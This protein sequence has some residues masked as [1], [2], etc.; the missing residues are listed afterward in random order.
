MTDQS[1]GPQVFSTSS[2]SRSIS[3]LRTEAAALFNR[4]STRAE[5]ADGIGEQAF[6]ISP[7]ADVRMGEDGAAA[8][9]FDLRNGLGGLALQKIRKGDVCAFFCQRQG[10]RFSDAPRPAGDDCCLA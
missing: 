1:V 5:C 9:R 6:A 10:R 8:E 4:M 3:S 2:T 7:L